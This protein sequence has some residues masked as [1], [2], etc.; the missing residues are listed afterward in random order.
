MHPSQI[1]C[2]QLRVEHSHKFWRWYSS[3][4]NHLAPKMLPGNTKRKI[5]QIPTFVLIIAHRLRNTSC[6][7]RCLFLLAGF[8]LTF[9]LFQFGFPY[10][11]SKV[12]PP[13]AT[14]HILRFA[15]SLGR[16][17]ILD[18]QEDES[19]RHGG[20]PLHFRNALE[21]RRKSILTRIQR[22]QTPSRLPKEKLTRINLAL[23]ACESRGRENAKTL[24]KSALLFSQD[25]HLHVCV[26]SDNRTIPALV[27]DVSKLQIFK[28]YT[29]KGVL[30]RKVWFLF[31]CWSLN[32][33]PQH[34]DG[35]SH[36]KSIL[37]G[38]PRTHKFRGGKCG[39]R[40]PPSGFFCL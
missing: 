1:S 6:A 20:I 4:A 28:I 19:A 10:Q 3:V 22:G 8:S 5:R 32:G 7:T 27:L 34:W 31:R 13:C 36:L 30:A 21:L 23:V 15:N 2:T 24:L 14:E 18:P 29:E 26:F 25:A 38:F 40:A 37:N 39:R 33:Q 17:N 11:R 12:A 9:F 16:A 35:N